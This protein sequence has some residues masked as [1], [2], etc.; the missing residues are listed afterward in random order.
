MRVRLGFF[1]FGLL[2][3]SSSALIYNRSLD[4][5]VIKV[6][7]QA[8]LNQDDAAFVLNN[9]GQLMVTLDSET[10][11]RFSQREKT[12]YETMDFTTRYI[13]DPGLEWGIEELKQEGQAG[14]VIKLYKIYE[15]AG[16]EYTRELI[17][18]ERLAPQPQIIARGT[19]IVVR[20]LATP[21]GLL[22]Y[23]RQLGVWATSYDGNCFGC[24]GKTYSGTEVKKGVCAV[25]PKV[26][27]LGS[28]FYVPGYGRCHAE[29]IGGH[30][31]GSRVDLGFE[32][33][34]NGSWSAR[35][36]DIYLLP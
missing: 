2:T 34:K 5:H 6:N 17:S 28:W 22:E 18:Q 8:T 29:D 16:E 23:T 9:N 12:E 21:K 11:T 1:F 31:K 19:K 36:V 13:D 14:Q 24:R 7:T 3:L 35:W 26:I 4:S 20:Q 32:D 33:L 25:D 10:L 30:I 27:P 15:Y